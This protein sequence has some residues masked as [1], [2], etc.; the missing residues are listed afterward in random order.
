VSVHDEIAA[1][2][3]EWEI[4]RAVRRETEDLLLGDCLP[5]VWEP[6]I[7]PSEEAA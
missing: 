1:M 6:P 7:E 5:D 2:H 3:R 4:A